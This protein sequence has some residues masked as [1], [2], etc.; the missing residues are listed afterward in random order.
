MAHFLQNIAV[1]SI[2][3]Y[4][5]YISP[6]KGFSCAHRISLGSG[7]GC[8][9]Y[10][11][12]VFA[13]YGLIKGYALLQRR[14]YDCRWHSLALQQKRPARHGYHKY[15]GGVLD[16]CDVLSAC[17]GC[18]APDC[19]LPHCSGSKWNFCTVADMAT[20]VCSCGDWFSSSKKRSATF[21]EKRDK[22]NAAKL[23]RAQR[24]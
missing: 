24:Q 5:K 13:R 8:S 4:Q 12:K 14:F 23:Q 16:A 18:H 9:G 20:D 19:D 15:Q 1:W 6:Y 7:T 22:K 10:A 3:L 21:Q 11:K 2:I 17:D